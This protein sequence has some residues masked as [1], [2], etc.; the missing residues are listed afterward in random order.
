M[1]TTLDTVVA[2]IQ[3]IQCDARANGLHERPRW[4]MIILRSLK[5]WTGPKML[6]GKPVEGTFR[7]HQ[8]PVADF[9]S[10]PA[11]LKVLEQ[12]LTSYR[13]EELFG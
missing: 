9:A 10:K 13:P 6:D 8:V 11:H 12:W 3:R 1:A 2:E 7:S 5:G 4:P